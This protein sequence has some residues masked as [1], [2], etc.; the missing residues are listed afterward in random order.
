MEERNLIIVC[1]KKA[2]VAVNELLKDIASN[3]DKEGEIVGTTDGTVA[4]VEMTEEEYIQN[5]SSIRADEKRLFIGKLKCSESLL[6]TADIIFKK[7]GITYGWSGNQAILYVDASINKDE[8][9]ELLDEMKKANV[10]NSEKT[11]KFG[12]NVKT[13]TKGAVV[14]FAPIIIAPLFAGWIIKDF[15]DD[16]SKVRTQQYMYGAWHMY[17]NHLEEF[18]NK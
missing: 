11:N 8:Y 7:Y 5:K 10:G 6:P 3:D 1:E 14:L 17:M 4:C 16:K 18:M 2:Q 15:Y 13:L 12:F 9:A